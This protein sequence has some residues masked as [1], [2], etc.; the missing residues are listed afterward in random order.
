[1][2]HIM[3]AQQQLLP[4]ELERWAQSVRQRGLADAII[5]FVAALE[6]W[7]FVGSQFLWMLAPFWRGGKLATLAE[8]LEQP[9]TWRN[10]RRCLEGETQL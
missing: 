4:I 9:E 3:V 8:A 1:M 6:A 5:P 10:L 2:G 7:G